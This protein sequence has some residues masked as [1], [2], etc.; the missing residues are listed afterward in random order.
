MEIN[1]FNRSDFYKKEVVDGVEELDLITNSIQDFKFTREMT[2]YKVIDA[3][4]G[5]PDLISI[6]A[7]GD[8]LSMFKWWVL[9]YVND[10]V[11]PYTDLYEGLVLLVPHQKDLEDLL[12]QNGN[13]NR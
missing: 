7:Y 13:Q 11:D 6:K 10:I 8:K 4:I 3:D 5:R 2:Y 9:F 12:N 1:R